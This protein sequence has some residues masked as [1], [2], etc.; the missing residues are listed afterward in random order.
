MEHHQ[1]RISRGDKGSPYSKSMIVEERSEARRVTSERLHGPTGERNGETLK[2]P[3]ISITGALLAGTLPPPRVTTRIT[4]TSKL[5]GTLLHAYTARQASRIITEARGTDRKRSLSQSGTVSRFHR[6]FR[7]S[8]ATLPPPRALEAN[9]EDRSTPIGG[10]DVPAVQ[11]EAPI[12]IYS[13]VR[14]RH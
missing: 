7:T 1:V 13:L 6:L 14:D 8:R 9:V 11:R 10:V 5:H 4:A 2:G 3:C 12:Y